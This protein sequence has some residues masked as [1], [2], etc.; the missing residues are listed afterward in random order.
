MQLNLQAWH[1]HVKHSKA[2][3]Q[4]L[5]LSAARSYRQTKTGRSL[6][7]GVRDRLVR[8]LRAIRALTSSASEGSRFVPRADIV[9][10]CE[11]LVEEFLAT[12]D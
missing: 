4:T 1:A 6:G 10:R 7:L 3:T 8:F 12:K 9:D 11:P 5:E 2:R